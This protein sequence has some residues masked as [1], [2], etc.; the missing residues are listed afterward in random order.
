MRSPML[1][2]GLPRFLKDTISSNMNGF[3]SA[4]QAKQVG[5]TGGSET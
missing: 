2:K 5:R 4:I 3:A 1:I